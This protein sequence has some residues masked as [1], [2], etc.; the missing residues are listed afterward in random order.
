MG[1]DSSI[2]QILP[3]LPLVFAG[4]F[5][6][7]MLG[8]ILFALVRGISKARIRLI[9]LVGCLI[10]AFI[11][12]AVFKASATSF[13]P[14]LEESLKDAISSE[15]ATEFFK[16]VSG[17]EV[18]QETLIGFV[19]ALF[20]PLFFFAVFLVLRI[21]SEIVFFIVMLFVGRGLKEK[22]KKRQFP[23]PRKFGLGIAQGLLI[24]FVLMT[25]LYAYLSIAIPIVQTTMEQE[26]VQESVGDSEEMQAVQKLAV[27]TQKNFFYTA[28]GTLGGKAT[29]NFLTSFKSGGEK[30]TIV[31]EVNAVTKM[32]AEA[33]KLSEIQGMDSM[34][35]ETAEVVSNLMNNIGDSKLVRTLFGEVIYA[36]TDA[37][38]NDRAIFGLEKPE[39]DPIVMPLFD[40]IINDFHNDARIPANLSADFKTLG[41]MISI[42]AKANI[43]KNIS[44]E[45]ADPN[46]LIDSLA[47]GTVIK[48]LI[49]TFGKNGTLKNLIPEFANLGMRAI[50][51]SVLNLP[52]DAADIY[53]RYITDITKAVNEVLDSNVE[54]EA[55][56][57]DLT[58]K[59]ITALDATGW[60]IELDAS[61]VKLYASAILADVREAGIT[62]VSEDDVRDFFEIFSQIN[63]ESQQSTAP[64][65]VTV[66]GASKKYKG[67]LYGEFLQE[68]INNS[69]VAALVR[70]TNDIAN[71][72][73]QATSEEDFQA[74][75]TQISNP[76]GAVTLSNLSKDAFTQASLNTVSAIKE[77]NTFPTIRVT[78]DQ[79]LIDTKKVN[80]LLNASTIQDEADKIGSIFNTAIKIKDAFTD[81][82]NFDLSKLNDIAADLGN[83]LNKLDSTE[84]FDGKTSLMIKA[85][86][87]KE[88][89]IKSMDMDI[90][91]A[92]KL[93][94]AATESTN[95][96]KIDFSE[97]MKSISTG[98]SIADK[99]GTN[100]NITEED[101][102]NLLQTMTPQTA[103]M[104]KVYLTESRV[105][106][107]GLN[108]DNKASATARL[109]NAL[110]DEMSKDYADY[111]GETAAMLKMFDIA[112]A[113]TKNSGDASL[114]NHGDVQGKLNMTAEETVNLVMGSH[115]VCNAVEGAMYKDGAIDGEM[116]NPFGL[117]I[118]E[119]SN[120]YNE[121]EA[122]IEKYHNEHPGNEE[123]LKAFAALFG[124]EASFLE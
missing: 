101:V 19:A 60:E 46:A 40:V 2:A 34:T 7:A 25:P 54:D 77:G 9:I 29:S 23:L 85:I 59:M 104:L 91:T 3:K 103:A 47:T 35:E 100:A 50:G 26:A 57:D 48:D 13:Y 22:D 52:K 53:N 115:M 111:T 38:Q 20:A 114:F 95:G 90:R 4:L 80:S 10:L 14:Q 70:V 69:A 8:A 116:I 113:A 94:D 31:K 83:I 12:T 117:T 81:S 110:F 112:K 109:L 82:N 41:D 93:A 88:E 21:I 15:E 108:D 78:L 51:Q 24:F 49:T 44:G 98:A 45:N 106:G 119:D 89:V 105:K 75:L 118:P 56:I 5:V 68:Q 84:T 72:S 42:M 30:T 33:S 61:V 66:K 63:E 37:W 97:T 67:T 120:D 55:K 17:S 6:L 99:L 87:Q 122:A 92:T 86:F 16:M 65:A 1:G 64:L 74:K 18:L 96:G 58:N 27:N 28:Y 11:L 76:F 79:F 62:H 123:T 36:V 43:F 39:M 73:A 124:V 121:C 107:F 102:E 32:V 71:A